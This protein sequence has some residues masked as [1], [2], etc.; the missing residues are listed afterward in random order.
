MDCQL[1]NEL[2]DLFAERGLRCTR[3]RRAIYEAL[4]ADKSHP[5]ADQLFKDVSGQVTGLSL[6]TVYNT[7]E[8]FCAAGLVQKLPGSTGSGAGSSSAR[9]D[10]TL[11]NH[12]HLRCSRTGD[13]VDV[14][15]DLSQ[16]LL[17][18]LPKSILHELEERL[19]FHIDQVTIEL[20]GKPRS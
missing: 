9:Y 4:L 11:D 19:G 8:A 20:V 1:S 17:N 2:Q 7:L 6:A 18:A 13:V 16:T 14:P 10:A 12:L 3:Q 15:E 5:T